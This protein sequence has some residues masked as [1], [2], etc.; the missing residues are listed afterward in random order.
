MSPPSLEPITKPLSIFPS[1]PVKVTNTEHIPN[2]CPASTLAERDGLTKQESPFEHKRINKES[3]RG[4]K[5]KQYNTRIDENNGL[6][7]PVSY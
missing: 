3:D 2:F 4:G 7:F 5:K 6:H 1:V